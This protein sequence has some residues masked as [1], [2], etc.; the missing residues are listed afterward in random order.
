MG[1][2]MVKQEYSDYY[3]KVV[4]VDRYAAYQKYIVP[5]NVQT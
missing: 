5:S 2:T 4:T 1:V 3:S